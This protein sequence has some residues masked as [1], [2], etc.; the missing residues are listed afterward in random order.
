MPRQ[1]ELKIAITSYRD[2][3]LAWRQTGVGELEWGHSPPELPTCRGCV[4]RGIPIFS[5][6][7]LAIGHMGR[8]GPVL[9]GQGDGKS[10]LVWLGVKLTWTMDVFLGFLEIQSTQNAEIASACQPHKTSVS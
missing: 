7:E 5:S 2:T 10:P 1:R 3:R 9:S 4:R 6:A 8:G